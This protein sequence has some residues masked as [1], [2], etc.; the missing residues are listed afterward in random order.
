MLEPEILQEEIRT[1]VLAM[2]DES[3]DEVNKGSSFLKT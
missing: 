1:E 2:L 3:G